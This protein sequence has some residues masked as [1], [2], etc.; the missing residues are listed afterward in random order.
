[1]SIA[2]RAMHG[3]E[4]SPPGGFGPSARIDRVVGGGG[5]KGLGPVKHEHQKQRNIG[6]TLRAAARGILGMF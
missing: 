6:E 5:R 4:W 3:V 1:M 2:Q